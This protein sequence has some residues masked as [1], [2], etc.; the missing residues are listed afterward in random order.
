[1]VVVAVISA[2]YFMHISRACAHTHTHTN[3]PTRGLTS[4]LCPARSAR[5]AAVELQPCPFR[6]CR[7]PTVRAPQ[8]P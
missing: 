6:A 3:S 5:S 4:G 8:Q 2:W 7:S 1:V